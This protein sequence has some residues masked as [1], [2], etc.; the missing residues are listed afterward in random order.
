M[1]GRIAADHDQG[2][3]GGYGR[4][5]EGV[6]NCITAEKIKKAHFQ[7]DELKFSG[8]NKKKCIDKIYLGVVL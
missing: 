8:K 7:V 5:W 1:Q 2:T 3:G 4:S 6:V